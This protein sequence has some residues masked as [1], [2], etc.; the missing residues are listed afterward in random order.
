MINCMSKWKHELEKENGP[1]GIKYS[2]WEREPFSHCLPLWQGRFYFCSCTNVVVTWSHHGCDCPRGDP[3]STLRTALDSSSVLLAH[4][5]CTQAQ[6][7]GLGTADLPCPLLRSSSFS[8]ICID[9]RY[10]E[11][12]PV[13]A[14]IG[15]RHSQM[16]VADGQLHE[17]GYWGRGDALAS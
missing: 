7:G 13:G 14:Q 9:T 16:N 15:M 17:I 8:S 4:C 6:T 1:L 2:S 11:M 3:S 10:L 12:T 5:M